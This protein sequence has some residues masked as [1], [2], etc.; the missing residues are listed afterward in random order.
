MSRPYVLVVNDVPQAS[1]NAKRWLEPAGFE[2]GTAETGED[3]CRLCGERS[4][5]LILLDYH[6]KKDLKLGSTGWKTG[7]DFVPELRKACPGVCIVIMSATVSNLQLD[8]SGLVDGVIYVNG[9]R[10]DWAGL[11][12]SVWK[13]LKRNSRTK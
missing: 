9:G 1:A 4:P 7:I 11:A 10:F 2:V 6:L 12:G 3:G 8:E 13:Y 5:D